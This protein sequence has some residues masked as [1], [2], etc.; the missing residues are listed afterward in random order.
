M[1][2]T[3]VATLSDLPDRKP[4]YAL[5]GEVDLVVV[6]F[7]DDSLCLLR[8]LPASRRT[9]G[10]RFC[11]G[12]EPDVRR[13]LLGLPAGFSGVSEYANNE[14]LPKFTSWVEGDAMCLWTPTRLPHG[15]WIIPQPYNR[16]AYLGLYADP[17]PWRERGTLHGPDPAIC[18]ATA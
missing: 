16:D 11:R 14:A 12:Q 7:D 6:R 2:P 8:A 13:A 10:R 4:Q 18:E 1:T 3:K 5:V 15:R 9:H 17:V